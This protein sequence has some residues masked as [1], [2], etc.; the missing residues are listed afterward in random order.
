MGFH[1]YNYSSSKW[2]SWTIHLSDLTFFLLEN[3]LWI[4]HSFFICLMKSIFQTHLSLTVASISSSVCYLEF[5]GWIM[6]ALLN[7]IFLFT[8]WLDRSRLQSGDMPKKILEC[9]NFPRERSEYS[10]ETCQEMLR[11]EII[12]YRYKAK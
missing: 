5:S 2:P 1:S 3:Y 11:P 6:S 12:K 7:G 4:D 8:V 9:W 10:T